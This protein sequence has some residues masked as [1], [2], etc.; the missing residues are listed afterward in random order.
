MVRP[1]KS[2]KIH[3]FFHNENTLDLKRLE[4]VSLAHAIRIHADPESGHF[5]LMIF[6]SGYSIVAIS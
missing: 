3:C 5:P 1:E 2:G 4:L 6:S